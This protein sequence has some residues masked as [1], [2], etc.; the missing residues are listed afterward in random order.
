[1]VENNKIPSKYCKFCGWEFSYE[2]NERLI[3]KK[4]SIIC[5]FCGIEFRMPSIDF[6]QYNKGISIK[7]LDSKENTEEKKNRIVENFRKLI[8]PRKYSINVFIGD[9]DLPKIFKENLIIVLSR[10]IYVII[11]EWEQSNN[12]SAVKVNLDK[13]LLYNIIKRINPLLNKRIK[14]TFL[15]NLYKTSIKDFNDWLK[16]FQNKL[17]LNQNYYTHFK[18][19]LNWLIRFVFRLIIDM[20]N[21]KNLPKMHK[22]I[23]NDLKNFNF[24]FSDNNSVNN[25][26]TGNSKAF[27]LE[28]SGDLAEFISISLGD[29]HIYMKDSH[30][31]VSIFIDEKEKKYISYV[32]NLIEKL[33][34]I[35]PSYYVQRNKRGRVARLRI[36]R[37]SI[38]LFLLSQGLKSGNKVENQVSI[39]D[40]IKN[41]RE[42]TQRSLK[43]LIDTD[44]TI[45]PNRRFK[46]ITI[47]FSN[48]SIPLVRDFKNMCNS[49]DISTSK[50]IGPLKKISKISGK[51]S[52]QYVVSIQA[53]SQVK[54]FIETIKP[55]KWNYYGKDILT[56]IG[57]TYEEA[58]EY[59]K[60][61]YNLET[62]LEWKKLLER[63]GSIKR[64]IVHLKKENA[65]VPTEKSFKIW[66]QLLLGNTGY[67]LWLKYNSNLLLNDKTKTIFQFP[68]QL[69]VLICQYIFEIL[70]SD[71][72][73]SETKILEVLENKINENDLLG[74]LS[75]LLNNSKTRSI[76]L[77]YVVMLIKFVKEI[78]SNFDS[79]NQIYIKRLKRELKLSIHPSHIKE[80]V[81]KLKRIS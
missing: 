32:K 23:I 60:S 25:E 66:M 41:E 14:N 13:S 5:E 30:Y 58:F 63:T 54:K 24:N 49:L 42:F 70:I 9:D 26:D 57:K 38:V 53:K 33:F 16:M 12:L 79:K 17:H 71:E 36:T 81:E 76:I 48:A 77:E 1:M 64:L 10:L 15:K 46:T 6:H 20:W 80:I 45:S 73:S 52:K 75:Y 62:A 27:H 65:F 50:I 67:K 18:N 3:N 68:Q 37:K 47:H 31:R 74:R 19:F 34:R 8:Q 78:R 35:T 44:G 7:G 72:F 22:T 4:D 43:G 51:T 28:K 29:G 56:D 21:M 69:R 55:N 2:I 39:P 40:W 61:P 59:V 11:R